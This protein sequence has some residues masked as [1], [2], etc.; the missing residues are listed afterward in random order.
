[1]M[2]DEDT[3]TRQ[4]NNVSATQNNVSHDQL[5]CAPVCSPVCAAGFA[6]VALLGQRFWL[7]SDFILGCA[8]DFAFPFAWAAP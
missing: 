1:M 7:R 3:S 4:L 5:I 8:L 2:S 6:W